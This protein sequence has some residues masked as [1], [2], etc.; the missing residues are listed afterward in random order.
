MFVNQWRE[1]GHVFRENWKA[2]SPGL[3]ECR[4]DIKRVPENDDVDHE[5]KSPKLVFLSFPIALA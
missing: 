2:L 3:L 4:I 5:A 1:P